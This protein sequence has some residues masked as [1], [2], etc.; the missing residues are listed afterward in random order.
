[1]AKKKASSA[2]GLEGMLPRQGR[3]R[4]QV[5][6]IP[7]QYAWMQEGVEAWWCPGDMAPKRIRI[8][9]EPRLA[10]AIPHAGKWRVKWVDPNDPYEFPAHGD[11]SSVFP[12]RVDA[13]QAMESE[14]RRKAESLV[15]HAAKIRQEIAELLGGG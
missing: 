7:P 5:V 4:A 12:N 11:V 10:S 6:P 9:G 13:L 14:M 1:M 2:G 8:A 3:S 15:R